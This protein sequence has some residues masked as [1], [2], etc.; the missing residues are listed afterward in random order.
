MTFEAFIKSHLIRLPP[1]LKADSQHQQE[2]AGN[3]TM[4]KQG[5]I[6]G[7]SD[8]FSGGA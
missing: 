8:L 5:K 2:D 1:L 4:W 7:T 6:T 3:T